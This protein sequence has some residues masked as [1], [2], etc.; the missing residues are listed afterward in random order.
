VFKEFGPLATNKVRYSINIRYHTQN[1]KEFSHVVALNVAEIRGEL[2]AVCWARLSE[3][4]Q[5]AMIRQIH[6]ITNK[7]VTITLS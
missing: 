3:V 4:E 1:E 7:P 2:Q 6:Q 5:E